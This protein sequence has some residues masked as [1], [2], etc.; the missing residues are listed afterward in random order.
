MHSAILLRQICLSVCLSVCLSHAGTVSKRMHLSSNSFNPLIG[1]WLRFWDLSLLQ[2]SKG[3]SQ[4]GVKYTT[5]ICDCRQKL[6]FISETVRDR[7]MVYYR[8]LTGSRADRSV[9]VPWPWVTLKGGT[10]RVKFICRMSVNYARMVWHRVLKFGTI[11][12]VVEKRVSKGSA[13]PHPK[14]RNSGVPKDFGTLSGLA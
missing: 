8:S 13:K 11:T 12:K 4:R 10:R 14:G 7:P 9:S 3:N 2:N 5:G 6:P 1:A